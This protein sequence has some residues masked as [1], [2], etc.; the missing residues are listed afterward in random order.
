MA[1]R[2]TEAEYV[3]Q[4]QAL[5]ERC[6]AE[7]IPPDKTAELEFG[8]TVRFRLGE[9][10]PSERLAA[11]WKLRQAFDAQR[12]RM[13]RNVK[14]PLSVLLCHL[15]LFFLIRKLR[16]AFLTVLTPEQVRGLLDG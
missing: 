13:G 4:L 3:G 15:R 2:L 1:E 12:D 10:L 6:A 16:R 14:G 9:D 8:L 7:G 11:L 5:L